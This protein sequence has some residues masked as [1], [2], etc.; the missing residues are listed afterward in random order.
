MKLIIDSSQFGNERFV[1]KHNFIHFPVLC[2][3]KFPESRHTCWQTVF[4][5]KPSTHSEWTSACIRCRIESIWKCGR[6]RTIFHSCRG[7]N[8]IINSLPCGHAHTVLYPCCRATQWAFI[9][10][11][12]AKCQMCN[13]VCMHIECSCKTCRVVGSLLTHYHCTL[14]RWT[15]IW[16]ALCNLHENCSS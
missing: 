13:H 14:S 16:H 3:I 8:S 4:M 9:V 10:A 15:I 5:P 6:T 7:E 11:F 1:R 12:A 2:S